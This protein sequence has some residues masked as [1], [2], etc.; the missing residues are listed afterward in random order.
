MLNNTM[1]KK[2]LINNPPNGA[3]FITGATGLVGSHLAGELIKKGQ[4]VIILI[5]SKGT[6]NAKQRFHSICEFLNLGFINYSNVMIVEGSLDIPSFGLSK[7][8]YSELC[9]R[10]ARIIHCAGNTTF[11]ERKVDES[12]RDNIL[13]LNNILK[14]ANESNCLWFHLIST[15][16][17]AE[18]KS[19]ICKE[20]LNES[21][22]FINFYEETKSRGEKITLNYCHENAICATIIRPS[23]IVG[24]SVNGRTLRFNGLYYPIKALIL[25]RDMFYKELYAGKDTKASRI[26]ISI[27]KG[28]LNLPLR[29]ETNNDEGINLVPIDFV[30]NAIEHIIKQP[31]NGSIYHI[32]SKKHVTI[33][34]L[35]NYTQKYFNITGIMPVNTGFFFK[36]NKT[37]LEYLFDKYT[38]SYLPYMRDSRKF[39]TKNT[40]AILNLSDINCPV[41]D[42]RLFARC[43]KYAVINNWGKNI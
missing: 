41:F 17:T 40:D 42:Y 5:R 6:Q 16:Y 38:E 27:K 10:T 18:M 35:I 37:P 12:E 33:A 13:G 34:Q 28:K 1:T 9:K 30:I 8:V 29:L 24:N 26:S 7:S 3:T 20:E 21:E 11:S 2:T 23:I 19:G 4:N 39:S 36:E 43:M 14:F 31:N 32:A 25:I 15:I 22:S